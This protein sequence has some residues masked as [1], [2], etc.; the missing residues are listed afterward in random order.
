VEFREEIVQ[1]CID[2]VIVVY[3]DC[4]V[5]HLPYAN[6]C[7]LQ[8]GVCGCKVLGGAGRGLG[9]DA[10]WTLP[11]QLTRKQAF[12]TIL[13]LIIL[14]KKTIWPHNKLKTLSVERPVPHKYNPSAGDKAKSDACAGAKSIPVSNKHGFLLKEWIANGFSLLTL[15]RLCVRRWSYFPCSVCTSSSRSTDPRPPPGS[16]SGPKSTSTPTTSWTASRDSSSH[17]SS[18]TSMAKYNPIN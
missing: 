1:F 9:V 13:G 16:A 7:G 4:S 6:V 10:E 8:D 15:V 11:P 3:D 17:S 2:N 14:I 5:S 12:K 18:A